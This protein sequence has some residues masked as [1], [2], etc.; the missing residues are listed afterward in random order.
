MADIDLGAVERDLR[1]RHDELEE[2][3]AALARPPERGSLVG[4]GKRIGDGTTEAVSRLTD[5]GVGGSLELSRGA[6]RPRPGQAR[7]G[8][9]RRLR[10]LRRADRGGP[11]GRRARERALHRVRAPRALG[12]AAPRGAEPHRTR[13]TRHG[14]AAVSRTAVALRRRSLAITAASSPS[15]KAMPTAGENHRPTSSSCRSSFQARPFFRPPGWTTGCSR[16]TG[17]RRSARSTARQSAESV[18]ARAFASAPWWYSL[19]AR[20]T[21]NGALKR[22]GPP[23]APRGLG[24]RSPGAPRRPRR[25]RPPRSRWRRARRGTGAPPDNRARSRRR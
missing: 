15:M 23:R 25:S 20:E 12:T 11:P 9:L 3:L 14:P 18:S 22:R 5:V 10:R 21:A 17:A 13:R 24:D 1:A 16:A 6:R 7:R 4:F 19:L 8:N 2:R